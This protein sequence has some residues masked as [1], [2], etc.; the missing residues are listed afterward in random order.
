MPASRTALLLSALLLLLAAPALTA[1]STAVQHRVPGMEDVTIREDVAFRTVG[2]R[3]LRA[4]FFYPAGHSDA[5]PAPAVI[6]FNGGDGSRRNKETAHFVSWAQLAAA[7]GMV[8]V[9]FD[10]RPGEAVADFDA[11]M[12]FMQRN[13]GQLGVDADR[14]AIWSCATGVP[15]AVRAAMG[16]RP[17][18]R[19]FVAYY[20]GVESETV[21]GRRDVP[22][23]VVM[24]GRDSDQN[25]EETVNLGASALVTNAPLVFLNYPEGE[26]GFEIRNPGPKTARLVQ[27]TLDFFEE[28]LDG[29]PA[30]G[31]GGLAGGLGEVQAASAGGTDDLVARAN[32]HFQAQEWK[33]A[34]DLFA[35]AVARDPSNDL[36]RFL[37]GF[38]A[39]QLDKFDLAQRCFEQC[40]ER[41]FRVPASSYNV[42]CCLALKNEADPAFTW[43]ER[44][45]QAGFAQVELY[46]N[47][48]DISTLRGDPRYQR[49][50]RQLEGG[51]DGPSAAE[52]PELVEAP[53]GPAA[54]PGQVAQE[55]Q[56][57]FQRQDWPKAYE[58]YDKL[59]RLV[60]ENGSAH[61]Q[62]G[63]AAIQV[64]KYERAV[65]AFR[66]AV[67]NDFQRPAATYNLA[68]CYALMGKKD[69][70]F[71]W[72]DVAIQVGFAEEELLRNDPDIASLRSD[73]R[74]RKYLEQ[75]L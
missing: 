56:A 33:P 13:A 74:F 6:F 21:L 58:L 57:A 36:A 11:L 42:A 46:R 44:A 50:L 72:L 54:N 19:G 40:V 60:P 10:S 55:A 61:F 1:Q 64:G 66:S 69:E 75:E 22:M 43:L 7:S 45:V 28:C 18:V 38:S 73:P 14:V 51:S 48:P 34:A 35:L 47:D 27:R 15:A 5:E 70:A 63:Y 25:R 62:T 32:G 39:I 53:S 52:A 29:S 30:V 37:Q 9:T 17:G 4:D 31:G 65:E 49:I 67:A 41:G 16:D 23:L 3:A 59:T 8:G 26:A 20:G 71:E 2:D 68:C 24:A 12:N